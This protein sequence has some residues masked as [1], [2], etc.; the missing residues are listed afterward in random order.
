MLYRS[1]LGDGKNMEDWSFGMYDICNNGFGML[2]LS[3]FI[4]F[5]YSGRVIYFLFFFL[6]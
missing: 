1:T 4:F 5:Q 3:E 2:P 6:Y